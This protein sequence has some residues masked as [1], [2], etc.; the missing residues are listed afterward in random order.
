MLQCC[1][2][3]WELDNTRFNKVITGDVNKGLFIYLFIYIKKILEL[4]ELPVKMEMWLNPIP[5]RN[6]D[7]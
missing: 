3:A 6:K 1:V 4:Q 5:G 7:P 2:R